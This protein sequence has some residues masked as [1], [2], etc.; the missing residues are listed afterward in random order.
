MRTINFSTN[1][2]NKL[3]CDAFTTIRLENP[4][5]Y[6]VNEVYSIQLQN[7]HLFNARIESIK[8]F[9]LDKLNNFM[10]RIDTGYSAKVCTGIIEKM[11][12]N[13]DL[14]V[15]PLWFILILKEKG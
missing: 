10:A 11:Y 15:K 2:N 7:K 8:P 14:K 9:K 5:K 4:S 1:W 3:D 12:G 6:I 13:V